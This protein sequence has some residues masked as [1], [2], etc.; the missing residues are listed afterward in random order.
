[1]LTGDKLETA[2][3]IAKSCRLIEGDFTVLRFSE[4]DNKALR[5]KILDSKETYHMCIKEKKRKSIV[6]DGE[7]LEIV[8][9]DS[10]LKK[11]FLKMGGGCDSVVCCRVTPK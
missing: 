7:A 10:W 3:N 2:E 8:L 11:E 9:Q 4:T 5:T 1:M 6:I